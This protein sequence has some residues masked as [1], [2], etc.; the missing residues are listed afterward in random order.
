MKTQKDKLPDYD[1][2]P[3]RQRDGPGRSERFD[4]GSLRG[5]GYEE[6]ANALS[7]ARS[8][9]AMEWV[10]NG[11]RFEDLRWW[12]KKPQEPENAERIREGQEQLPEDAETG[13]GEVLTDVDGVEVRRNLVSNAHQLVE[14]F[15]GMTVDG[16]V[17]P[18]YPVAHGLAYQCV[19]YIRRYY[20]LALGHT[21]GM[22]YGHAKDYLGEGD[23]GGLETHRKSGDALPTRPRKGDLMVKTS[24]NFGHVAIVKEASG[25][26]MTVAQQN[27]RPG[28]AEE[29]Y[30]VTSNGAGGWKISGGAFDWSGL[31]RLSDAAA[32]TAEVKD[33]ESAPR[34]Q[35]DAISEIFPGTPIAPV[36]S[37][38]TYRVRPG[39]SLSVI[40]ER[41]NVAGGYM[42]LARLNNIANPSAIGVG[43]V[44]KIP[45]G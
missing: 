9:Y 10:T 21:S 22:A 31:R 41:F 30:S 2:A 14:R 8:K 34:D 11:C 18:C 27:V 32:D 4:S 43:Q 36:Q 28:I 12:F 24:G 19:E 1:A 17:S 6:G 20:A 44:L 33:E 40:A 42:E 29:S 26:R 16:G 39:D 7:P 15:P 23:R 45:G 38:R 35:A 25:N 5:M 37:G 3:A 13:W